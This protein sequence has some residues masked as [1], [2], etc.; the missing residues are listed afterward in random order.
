MNRENV[1]STNT[2]NV[3]TSLQLERFRCM[4]QLYSGT[5]NF[6]DDIVNEIFTLDSQRMLRRLYRW[7]TNRKRYFRT[8]NTRKAAVS[9]VH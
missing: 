8:W 5:L 6:A 1:Q 7:N 2:F 9:N 3:K 4:K